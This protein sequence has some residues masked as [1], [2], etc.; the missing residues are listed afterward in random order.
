[1]ATSSPA[2]YDFGSGIVPQIYV[3][4]S[5]SIRKDGPDYRQIWRVVRTVC[6]L[7]RMRLHVWCLALDVATASRQC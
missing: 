1:M 7:S 2:V 6:S 4:F 5:A 3:L